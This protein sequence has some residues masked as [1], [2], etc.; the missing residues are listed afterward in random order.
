M[1][2]ES[3]SMGLRQ[4]DL[5]DQ[6]RIELSIRCKNGVN[7]IL[8]AALI[9]AGIAVIWNWELS[10]YNQSIL[11]FSISGLML[12]LAWIFGKIL[13]TAWNVEGNPLNK[14]GLIFNLAQLFYFPFLFILL[15]NK[16]EFFA[17]GYAIIT[18]A[19]FFPYAWYYKTNWFG[20]FAGL[21]PFG[22][23]ILSNYF[24]EVI[25]LIPAFVSGCLGILGLGL[26]RD[27]RLK[28]LQGNQTA[29]L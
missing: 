25:G 13:K 6:W 19:H 9:W 16:P 26:V 20:V 5:L 10:T 28:I 21:I 14:V 15:G 8:A 1:K 11:T 7:F 27:Y 24:P 18:G 3:L 17:L 12:P 4:T 23:W 2:T 22:S 29:I